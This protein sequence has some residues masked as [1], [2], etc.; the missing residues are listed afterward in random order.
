MGHDIPWE[1]FSDLEGLHVQQGRG[2]QGP[3]KLDA[4]QAGGGS[5]RF[6]FLALPLLFSLLS[7]RLAP[8]S[9]SIESFLPSL[10]CFG[11]LRLF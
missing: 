1:L 5:G 3:A 11:I 6:A 4:F 9:N 10:L 2:H 8:F 7:M